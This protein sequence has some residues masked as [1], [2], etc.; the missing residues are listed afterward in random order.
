MDD[1]C[2][3]PVSSNPDGQYGLCSRL[4]L[5]TKCVMLSLNTDR[6]MISQFDTGVKLALVKFTFLS[7]DECLSPVF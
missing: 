1:V 5:V 7:R 6:T 2:F 3:Y 4:H